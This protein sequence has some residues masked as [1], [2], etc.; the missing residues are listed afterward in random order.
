MADVYVTQ[1]HIVD[2]AIHEDSRGNNPHVHL[3][4]ATRAVGADGF[5]LKLREADGL[6]FVTEA[7]EIWAKIANA[8][9]GKEGADFLP[10]K[11]KLLRSI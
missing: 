7:R 2:I 6:A 8:A 4:L 5:K 10:S 1:G 9:L 3:M 11:R